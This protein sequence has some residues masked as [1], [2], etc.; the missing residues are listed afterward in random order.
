MKLFQ[1]PPPQI[2]GSLKYPL[3]PI[4]RLALP[5]SESALWPT[6]MQLL[7]REPMDFSPFQLRAGDCPRPFPESRNGYLRVIAGSPKGGRF[8]QAR[9]RANVKSCCRQDSCHKGAT[10]KGDVCSHLLHLSITTG[11]PCHPHT[12]THLTGIQPGTEWAKGA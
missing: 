12:A 10:S 1:L 3:H 6:R 2:L 4:Y 5:C 9:S 7:L 11:T 8:C